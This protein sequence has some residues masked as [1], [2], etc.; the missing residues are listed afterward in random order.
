MTTRCCIGV[1]PYTFWANPPMSG[2]R[3]TAILEWSMSSIREEIVFKRIVLGLDGSDE[4]TNALE[5]AKKLATSE[6]AHVE[7]VHV[8]EYMIG[9][10]AGMQ[11]V[12]ADEDE[13]EAIVR[14]QA[15]ALKSDGVD[16]HLTIVSTSAGGPAHVLAD[17]ARAD[18]ADVI[19][20]GT[21][22]RTTLAGLLLGER[23]AAAD[24]RLTVPGARHSQPGVLGYRDGSADHRGRE[25][26]GV[27]MTSMTE[28]TDVATAGTGAAG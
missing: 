23:D 25:L 9:G 22:G 5:F 15:E 6:D 7:I 24:A 10:R 28:T 21:R 2:R 8:H 16:A 1:F 4:S 18:G 17:H 14:R 12:R 3:L 13:L 20:V 11:P 26:K 27:V 19:V